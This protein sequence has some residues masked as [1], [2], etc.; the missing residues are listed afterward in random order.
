MT[1]HSGL[2]HRKAKYYFI[3]WSNLIASKSNMYILLE[4][5]SCFPHSLFSCFGGAA[6]P[7]RRNRKMSSDKCFNQG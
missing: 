5:F 7:R 1:K 6:K 3:I 2:L 4:A